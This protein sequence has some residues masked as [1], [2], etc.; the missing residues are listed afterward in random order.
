MHLLV[1]AHSQAALL[2]GPAFCAGS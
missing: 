2:C 1:S